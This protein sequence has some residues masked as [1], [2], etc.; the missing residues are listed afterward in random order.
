MENV[1]NIHG[2]LYLYINIL[3]EI[4]NDMIK[5]ETLSESGEDLP[6]KN[7][8][9][10][11]PKP[12]FNT[13]ASKLQYIETYD[14]SIR[15]GKKGK[16]KKLFK[17]AVCEKICKSMNSLQYH[18]LS[19]TGERPHQCKDCGQG[20]MAN[21]AL[22][23]HSLLHTGEKPHICE[24]C[25]RAFR[26][27]GDLKYHILSLHT[28]EKSYQCEYCGKDFARRYSL[29]LHR[30]IHT[31]ER[32]YKCEICNKSFRAS[33]YLQDHRRIHTG[34]HDTHV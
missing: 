27:W 14:E 29:V 3:V 22:K 23:V 33:T 25:S 32:N 12:H 10:R 21:S 2:F 13:E 1:H 31:G 30:R 16:F 5:V 18:F 7:A 6:K 28:D 9:K 4:D 34:L 17:C 15:V 26:Q 24:I 8:K 11:G 20:F 19:H